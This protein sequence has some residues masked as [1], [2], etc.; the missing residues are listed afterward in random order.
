MRNTVGENRPLEVSRCCTGDGG[1]AVSIS[2]IVQQ[3]PEK[4]SNFMVLFVVRSII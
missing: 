4:E 3:I 2:T 1:F